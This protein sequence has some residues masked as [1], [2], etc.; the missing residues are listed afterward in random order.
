[1]IFLDLLIITLICVFVADFT[2]FFKSLQR[3]IGKL[4]DIKNVSIKVLNCS[5][6][7]TWWCSLTYL[8]V[9]NQVSLFNIFVALSCAVFTIEIKY[10]IQLIKDIITLIINKIY[11]L[12]KI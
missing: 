10:I 11:E 6:C 8:I 4:L 5:L 3:A 2:D 1:M 7:Q 9:N 12:L